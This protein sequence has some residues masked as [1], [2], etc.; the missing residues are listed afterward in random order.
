[1]KK[2]W[3]KK[4]AAWK[5]GPVKKWAKWKSGPSE[6][7]GQVKKW[8]KWKNSHVKKWAEWKSCPSAKVGWLKKWTVWKNGL[9]E[10]LGR[11]QKWAEWKSGLCGK[12][13]EM[14]K[15]AEW[16]NGPDLESLNKKN[17]TRP[18]NEIPLISNL[19]K[20]SSSD[21]CT[22]RVNLCAAKWGCATSILNDIF[23]EV[24]ASVNTFVARSSL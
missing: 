22:E 19:V 10:K 21:F 13:G 18:D 3:V 12:V 23:N 1:M 15:L 16:K 6:K 2:C 5:S 9:S 17:R 20:M 7:V 8:A 24:V 4:W 14:K 11:V